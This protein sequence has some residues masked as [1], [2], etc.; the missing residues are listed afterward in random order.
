VEVV[1]RQAYHNIP[2]MD[3]PIWIVLFTT[4]LLTFVQGNDEEDQLLKYVRPSDDGAA[5]FVEPFHSL[6]EFEARW[7]YSEAKKD[8]VDEAIAKYDGKWS[9]AEPKDNPLIGDSGLVLS[10]EAK[11]AAVS[12]P[13]QTPFKFDDNPL[14][15]QY[16]VRFQKRHECG[17]AYI[18]LLAESENLKLDEFGDKTEYVVMFGPDKCGGDG[19]MHFIFQHKN[20]ITHKMEEKHAKK[21][22][23]EFGN[24]FDDGKTHL[25]GLIVRPDNTFEIQV[26]KVVI[27]S[28]NLLKDME[29][30]INP[31]KL[32]DD[33]E[34]V[35]PEDWDEREKITDPTAEKPADWDEDAP[36]TIE[37]PNATKPEG[38]L[39]DEPELVPDPAA[40]MPQDW[41]ESEDGEW[42]APQIP[43][44]NCKAVGCG[45]WKPP[46]I[47]NPEYKG[48]WTAP[49]ITNPD[50]KGVWKAKQIANPNYFEDN[51]PFRMKSIAAVGFELWSMQS[52]IVFDNLIIAD[53]MAIAN[54][55]TLQTWDLKHTKEAKDTASGG[56]ISGL[57]Q[58][59]MDATQDKPWL[60]VVVVV[61][62]L[63][64]I[65][66]IYLLC[67]T[68]GS[69]NDAAATYKKTDEVLPDDDGADNQAIDEVSEE[70]SSGEGN[71]A[72]DSSTENAEATSQ[73]EDS[74]EDI[75][76]E[77]EEEKQVE[78]QHVEEDEV[79]V[80]KEEVSEE[81]EV[82]SD[83]KAVE[84]IA[85]DN[86]VEDASEDVKS[87]KDGNEVDHE[88]SEKEESPKSEVSPVEEIQ[89]NG[90]TNGHVDSSEDLSVPEEIPSQPHHSPKT[91]ASKRKT[92]KDS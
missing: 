61:A 79:K 51:N 10:S 57:W 8:G 25:V 36:K 47:A 6:E 90:E 40:A 34:D 66:M 86:S 32:V 68:G 12:A 28:G 92:R 9:V 2:D 59:F 39:D 41:D 37:D 11:H 13:L 67:C 71:T 4:L 46:T 3:S 84:D 54:Q 73:V 64:P 60:W 89:T 42:E 16:E 1:Q 53:D 85:D 29:P 48:K 83:I 26:D 65:I 82:K 52:D 7:K 21:A 18:K 43:N 45:V 5:F 33:P 50:Y 70:T 49:L 58:S 30:S 69:K 56:G 31:P 44:P 81:P 72:A 78:E 38:W 74:V 63:L 20:P 88:Q 76:V 80:V 27:N 14:V 87:A 22:S 77:T 17:G 91:R 75:V 23:G 55:W 35:K 62:V 15:V 24:I 19:K